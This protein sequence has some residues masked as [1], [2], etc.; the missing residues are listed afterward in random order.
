M[1]ATHP[2]LEGLDALTGAPLRDRLVK[3][4]E[5]ALAAAAGDTAHPVYVTL[6]E[7]QALVVAAM[8]AAVGAV[9]AALPET[10][11][12]APVQPAAAPAPHPAPMPPVPTPRPAAA[13]PAPSRLSALKRK[14]VEDGPPEQPEP[15]KAAWQS[16]PPPKPQ[17]GWSTIQI[18]DD[19]AP[20]RRIEPGTKLPH[21]LDTP[22]PLLD[23]G[24]ADIPW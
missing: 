21:K 3:A 2:L 12:P 13:A 10:A 23:P 4:R 8:R 20:R 18:P 14:P 6:I 22:P 9:V 19:G 1:S 17:L 24:D 5:L 15:A 11:A 16:P 7:Q